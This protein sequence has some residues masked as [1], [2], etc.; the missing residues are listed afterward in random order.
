MKK[1]IFLDRD[2]V[3][4]KD[5]GYVH[6]LEEFQFIEGIFEFCRFMLS[7]DYLLIVI[8]NQAGIARGFYSEDDFL[9]LNDWMLGEFLKNDVIITKVYYCP[10][11]PEF[12]VG[13]YKCD[14]L[15][16]KPKPGM[17]LQAHKDFNVNMSQSILI[18]DKDS[19]IEAGFN[20]GVGTLIRLN[21]NKYNSATRIPHITCSDFADI[22]K[23][24][25]EVMAC[26]K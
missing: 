8:T 14:S 2:G 25:R 18:G 3:I 23:T 9:K 1:A 10:H 15:D 20:A 12:G 22:M 4:N 13:K 7:R 16:R 24:V 21:N 17:L 19:D 11:H 26:N 6:K 5:V